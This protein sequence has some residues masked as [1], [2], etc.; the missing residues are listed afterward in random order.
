MAVYSEDEDPNVIAWNKQNKKDSKRK[1]KEPT[2]QD[3]DL[4]P[5][6]LLYTKYLNIASIRYNLS[7]D[8]CR[9]KFGRYTTNEWN[10]FLSDNPTSLL[11]IYNT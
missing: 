10:K 9:D 11:K 4:L 6:I 3:G 2:K 7:L 8:E 5:P 1:S